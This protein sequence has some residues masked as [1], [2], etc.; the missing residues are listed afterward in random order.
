MRKS[1]PTCGRIER[2]VILAKD[3]HKIVLLSSSPSSCLNKKPSQCE[4]LFIETLTQIR[5]TLYRIYA[6]KSSG[7]CF[8][9][10]KSIENESFSSI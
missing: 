6:L 2:T 4:G 7:K 10:S 3:V 5:R 1:E 9:V 8:L